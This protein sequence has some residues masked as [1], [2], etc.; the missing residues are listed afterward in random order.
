MSLFNSVLEIGSED[1]PLCRA[2]KMNCRTGKVKNPEAGLQRPK[3]KVHVL[4]L[5]A[6]NINGHPAQFVYDV[7]L[8]VNQ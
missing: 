4:H 3:R 1:I 8:D 7:P 5:D 2:F 6:G